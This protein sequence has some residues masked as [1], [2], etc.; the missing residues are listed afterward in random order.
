MKKTR[1]L[2][3]I[4]SALILAGLT[5]CG[6]TAAPGDETDTPAVTTA[7][8]ETKPETTDPSKVL[9]LP[10]TNWNGREFRVLGYEG[11]LEQWTTFEITADAENGEVVNDAVF[12]RNR[13]V[14]EKY[15]VKIT[16]YK[17]KDEGLGV[18]YS[19]AP[20][21]QKFVMAGDDDFDLAFCVSMRIGQIARQGA[22]YD[23]NTVKNLNF[24]KDWWNEEVNDTLE[25]NGKLYFTSSDFS[26]RDKSR[27][28]I[29]V[30]NKDLSS[31]YKL[32]NPVELVKSG[33]WTFDALEKQAKAVKSD[34]NGNGEVDITDQFGLG[35][36]S[37]DSF[38]TFIFGAGVNTIDKDKNGKL[39]ISL[40]NERTTGAIDK[41]NKFFAL[42]DTTIV[43]ED[44]QGKVDGDYWYAPYNAFYAGRVLFVTAF[45]HLLRDM[46]A[47]CVDDYGIIP[48]PKYD[49]TQENYY[50]LANILGMLFGIPSTCA[51][52]DFAGFML[53]ALSAAS[54]DTS[55]KAY[56]DITC[57][58]KYTYDEDSAEMLD[59]IFDG[60][61]YNL[62]DI[63][64]ISGLS[65]I[66]RKVGDTRENTFASKYA[67]IESAALADLEKLDKEFSE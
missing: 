26:L 56:Y 46:S 2:S 27:A 15:G 37:G 28:Y 14:E 54:T 49:E 45:P 12:R 13:Q 20:Y 47:N 50:S 34:L 40:N 51:D 4:L 31:E 10:D 32:E 23:L 25:V 16:E 18:G 65:A 39:F 7:D 63:Y 3:L 6:D 38:S 8:S 22:F 58:T 35:V 24:S 43:P 53:E 29:M 17:F 64:N 36:D 60:I 19:T 59:L 30:Y 41:I 61:R 1:T 21:I 67:S 42:P 9:E 52:P 55:L 33:K 66:L 44:W 11:P 62:A 5:S 48:F 57:K